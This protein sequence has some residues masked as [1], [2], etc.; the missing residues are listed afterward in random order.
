M[1]NNMK[2]KRRLNGK[3]LLLESSLVQLQAGSVEISGPLWDVEMN[4]VVLFH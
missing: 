1:E 3:V 4:L 2:E